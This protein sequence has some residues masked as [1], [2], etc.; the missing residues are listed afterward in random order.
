MREAA[1]FVRTV[2]R[3][4]RCPSNGRIIRWQRSR[5]T[6]RS[7]THVSRCRGVRSAL[8]MSATALRQLRNL[9]P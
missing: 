4:G 1:P 9:L 3:A 6:G 2:R 8:G 5:L 7:L